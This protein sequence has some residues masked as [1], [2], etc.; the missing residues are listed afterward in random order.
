MHPTL[1]IVLAIGVLIG[2]IAF[3]AFLFFGFE[4]LAKRS[5]RKRLAG[6]HPHQVALPGDVVLSY[7]TYHG[8]LVWFTQTHHCFA[9]RPDDARKLLGRLL[10]FNLVW[11]FFAY[12]ALVIPLLALGNYLAQRRSIA[13]Q[14]SATT[15]ALIA[16]TT[17][18]LFGANQSLHLTPSDPVQAPGKSMARFHRFFGWIC[19]CLCFLFAI[20]TVASLIKREWEAVLGG[21][22]VTGL[23]GWIA[24]DWIG[25]RRSGAV[26]LGITK[27]DPRLLTDQSLPAI[28]P[29]RPG[30]GPS[31]RI[32]TANQQAIK[33]PPE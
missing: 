32:Q 27:C 15:A 19:A 22:F 23:V 9:L 2:I 4:A 3:G 7:H 18:S 10:R 30:S 26:V 31:D 13:T 29:P 11:G 8:F 6:L 21:I 1:S 33:R 24:Y 12:G 14:E 5:L 25:K 17:T 28:Q 16:N 20:V